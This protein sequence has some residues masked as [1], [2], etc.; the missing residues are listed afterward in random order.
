[1]TET[2]HRTHC[3]LCSAL[4]QIRNYGK[5][6]TNKIN[7]AHKHTDTIFLAMDLEWGK[8]RSTSPLFG[9]KNILFCLENILLCG[10]KRAGVEEVIW[11]VL[12]LESI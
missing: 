6:K 7:I 3:H 10:P 8:Q 12:E 9:K 2:E 1:M 5:G 11:G 4:A